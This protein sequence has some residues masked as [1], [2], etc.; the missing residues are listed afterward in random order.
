[1]CWDIDTYIHTCFFWDTLYNWKCFLSVLHQMNIFRD[2]FYLF[3]ERGGGGKM[4]QEP[5]KVDFL[6]LHGPAQKYQFCP[7][8][9]LTMAEAHKFWGGR[10]QNLW[11][12]GLPLE[13][14]S[15]LTHG[16]FYNFLDFSFLSF[17]FLS[18]FSSS[19][20]FR[21][22]RS[23]TE[24][25]RGGTCPPLLPLAVAFNLRSL[26]TWMKHFILYLTNSTNVLI[27]TTLSRNKW[28]QRDML[29]HNGWSSN[30]LPW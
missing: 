26:A 12:S 13:N 14:S 4:I 24:N 20:N 9:S 25:F 5:R 29:M 18:Y 21:G 1:M 22:G 6:D 15:V 7:C 16:Q 30:L 2:G 28:S 11:G 27:F 10:W 23:P 19:S 3:H 17:I 8:K